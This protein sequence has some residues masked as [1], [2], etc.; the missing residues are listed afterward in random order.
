MSSQLCRVSV[1]DLEA[2]AA[3][4]WRGTETEALGGWLLRAAG[5]FTGRSNSALPLGDPGL[6]LGQAVDR[7]ERWYA[8]RG[9]RPRFLLP[10]PDAAAVDDEL[11]RRG[12]PLGDVVR[13]L[14]APVGS[15]VRGHASDLS[16]GRP[17]VRVAGRPDDDWVGAYH[18]RGGTL[19]A[20]AREVIENGDTLAFASVRGPDGQVLAIARGSVDVDRGGTG[21]LGVT[22]VEVEPSARRQG[23]GG[24]IL[25]G[26][27]AWA[28]G[29][30]ARCCYLQVAAENA[31]ALAL[32]AGA[33]FTEH[34]TYQYRLVPDRGR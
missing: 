19:P 28:D 27:A 34:H 26:L 31:P 6:P 17:A 33:G 1:A 23:L 24:L 3:R 11:V 5:G 16:A 7:V 29:H 20:H 8:A 15:L 32:Y 9:L 25:R 18:Y 4:G 30:D 21:W 13:V 12:W 14:V 22:A 10:L 2:V